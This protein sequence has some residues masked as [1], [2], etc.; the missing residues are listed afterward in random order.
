VK[1]LRQPPSPEVVSFLA[2]L[3]RRGASPHTLRAYLADLAEFE[4]HLATSG[5]DI[6]AATH[7]I[8][9]AHLAALAVNRK[10]SSRARKLASIKALYRYLVR[11]KLL[12]TSPAKAV[13]T[14]KLPQPL[15]K[16]LPVDEAFALMESPAANTPLELRDRAILEVLY[17][18]GLRI[19]EL[20][21]LSLS[22]WDREGRVVRVMGKNSRER[23]CPVNP[24]AASALEA[25]LPRRGE[26]LAKGRTADSSALFVNYRGGRLRARSVARHFD[27]YVRRCGLLRKISPHALRHSFA[28]HLLA[29]GAD[30]RTIQ[31]L[32][33]HASL[34]TTQRYTHVSWER[35]QEVYDKAHP[36]A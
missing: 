27:R 35:L 25:Y 14:P 28:T 16:V 1:P 26:L 18:G 12:P 6:R 24:K 29:G 7:Q 23:L 10:A 8:I 3:R 34:S 36:R 17:G 4:G 15:P 21:S 31:E 30:V 22:D 2:H 9:R 19:S 13:R 5:S 11:Q 32:L 33:G 20:C